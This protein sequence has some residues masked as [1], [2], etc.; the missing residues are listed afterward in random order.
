MIISTTTSHNRRVCSS[1]DEPKVMFDR[2]GVNDESLD[3][4]VGDARRYVC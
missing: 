1:D 3:E 2:G 4:S